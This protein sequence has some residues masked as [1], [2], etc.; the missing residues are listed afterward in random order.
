MTIGTKDDPTI[1]DGEGRSDPGRVVASSVALVLLK[2]VLTPIFIGGASVGARRWGPALGGWIIALPLTSGPVALFLALDRGPAFA[3]ATAEASLAGCIAIAA[4]AVVY[5]RIADRYRWPVA[6]ASVDPGRRGWRLRSGPS[7]GTS[8]RSWPVARAGPCPRTGGRVGTALCTRRASW[9]SRSGRCRRSR[10]RSC[11]R[12]PSRP[13]APSSAGA[14][15]DGWRRGC[16]APARGH[17]SGWRGH[18][19][20]PGSRRGSPARVRAA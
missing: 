17:R 7:A 19:R 4:Y 20:G 11:T 6:L 16:A 5:A 15:K 14:S 10:K 3:A 18:R 9:G 8:G 1:A 2:L 13:P 12:V